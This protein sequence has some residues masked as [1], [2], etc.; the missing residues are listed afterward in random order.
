MEL[1]MPICDFGCNKE[2]THQFKS[3]G[4]WCCSTNHNACDGKRAKNSESHKGKI[5]NWKNGHPLGAKGKSPWNKGK[6]IG[7]LPIWDE[8]FSLEKCLVE[9]ST[10]AMSNLRRRLIEGNVL[11]YKCQICGIGP[12]WHGKSMPLILDH[13]NGVNN[14]NRLDNLRF[15]CS[16]CDSQ[17]DTYKSRNRRVA[18]IGAQAALKA[19][20]TCKG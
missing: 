1:L 11:E 12:E 14:D 16:N 4:K 8:K 9:H 13:I 10:Y 5:P 2:A 3:S 15:V 20:P 6:Q 17:L 19:V 18:S 7:R